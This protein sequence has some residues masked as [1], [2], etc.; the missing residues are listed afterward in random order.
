MLIIEGLITQ[1][2]VV[3]T[4][5][6]TGDEKRGNHLRFTN[7]GY[8]LHGQRYSDVGFLLWHT[9]HTRT[10]M[11]KQWSHSSEASLWIVIQRS[12]YQLETFIQGFTMDRKIMFQLPART[13][14]VLLWLVPRSESSPIASPWIAISRSKYQLKRFQRSVITALRSGAVKGKELKSDRY[15]GFDSDETVRA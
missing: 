14:L 13:I 11:C 7:G 9:R 5:I 1:G 10:Q 6:L 15:S 2:P 3:S 8:P 12:N 4:T